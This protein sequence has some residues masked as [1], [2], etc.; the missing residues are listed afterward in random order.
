MT[1]K[2]IGMGLFKKDEQKISEKK[3]YEWRAD[4][5][6]KRAPSRRRKGALCWLF[7][8]YVS[9][10]RPVSCWLAGWLLLAVVPQVADSVPWSA[11]ESG[12]YV[13]TLGPV[14]GPCEC[15]HV[16]CS[17]T[18]ETSWVSS[19]EVTPR[20]NAAAAVTASSSLA[21][22]CSAGLCSDAAAAAY[23]SSLDWLQ[24]LTCILGF[25]GACG[26]QKW[27]AELGWFL[28]DIVQFWLSRI[29]KGRNLTS[30]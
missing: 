11:L 1:K 25:A 19:L 24:H 3:W 18:N 14:G 21:T 26:V 15:S 17:L 27:I 10:S 30:I 6:E 16:G 4:K 23:A 20:D 22:W 29:K 9:G 7:A 8:F 12:Q 5:N 2:D 28:I 13:A